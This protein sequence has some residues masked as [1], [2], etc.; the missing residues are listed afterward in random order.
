MGKNKTRRVPKRASGRISSQAFILNNVRRLMQGGRNIGG[1]K[2]IGRSCQKK[3][4]NMNSSM[5]S[6]MY[7]QHYANC[8]GIVSISALLLLTLLTLSPWCPDGANAEEIQPRAV[9]GDDTLSVSLDANVDLLFTPM[10]GGSFSSDTAS[11]RIASGN[12]DGYTAYISTSGPSGS[13]AQE[14]GR[15]GEIAAISGTATA[16]SMN[17][18]WGYALTK[19]NV[20][21]TTYQGI[22]TDQEILVSTE[23][24]STDFYDLS[25]AAKVDFA[26]PSGRYTNEVLVSV[27][28]NPAKVTDLTSITYMQEMTSDI[29]QHTSLNRDDPDASTS[30]NDYSKPVTKQLIDKRDNKPYY[31]ARL[32]DGNCWMTQNLDLDINA[33]TGLTS[34]DTDLNGAANGTGDEAGLAVWK[35]GNAG[36]DTD[37][38]AKVAPSNTT[39]TIPAAQSNPSQTGTG[40]W[41]FGKWVL[42]I[43]EAAVTCGTSAT[44]ISQC[45]NVGFVNVASGYTD[46][47]TA[48]VG[49]WTAPNGTAYS[50]K[51]VAINEATKSYDPHYLIGNYYQWNTA[52]AGSGGAIVNKAARDSICP[53]G[54]QLPS[55]GNNTENG[56]FGFMLSKYG[57]TS[58]V[59]GKGTDGHDYNIASAPLSYVR[60]G[61]VSLVYGTLR[62]AGGYGYGWSAQSYSSGGTNAYNLYFGASD[63]APSYGSN[64]NIAFP[65][66][67][68]AK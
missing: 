54:W 37:G 16:E 61:D 18:N 45:T 40:S 49:T 9:A 62:I 56:T 38:A 67:C 32:A 7:Y 63:V 43:P 59:R 15:M 60:S 8:F 3:L 68:I 41:D 2:Y 57:L 27:V 47:Y 12:K 36:V 39:S 55:S 51:T 25:V 13:M 21:P 33:T 23:T 6:S 42:A 30:T 5:G 48:E 31:V 10:R 34:A 11:L 50:G 14:D 1:G 17:N 22:S 20:S 26:I 64:R 44:N 52:T 46:N 66:R 28:A 53:K 29:C 4:R 35:S 58:S 65:I 24:A 19:E